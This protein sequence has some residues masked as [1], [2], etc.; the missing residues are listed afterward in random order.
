MSNC[1][2]CYQGCA[3]TISD[4]CIK[5]TGID[6]PQ[7]GIVKGDSLAVVEQKIFNHLRVGTGIVIDLSGISICSIMQDYLPASQDYPPGSEGAPTEFVLNDVLAALIQY[8]CLLQ[9]QIGLQGQRIADNNISAQ[10]LI[11]EER[12]ART[13]EFEA[14]TGVISTISA[15]FTT[16]IQE[17]IALI[18]SESIARATADSATASVIETVSASINAL[19]LDVNAKIVQERTAAVT[20]EQAIATLV[21]TVSAQLNT[22][23]G[24][25]QAAVT[26][27]AQSIATESSARAT[28][29]TNLNAAIATETANRGT[30]ISAASVN[31]LQEANATAAAARATLATNLTAAIN[32]EKTNRE[33]AITTLQQADVTESTARAALGTTLNAAINTEKTNREAAVA[34]LQQADVTESQARATLGTNLTAA[35]NTEASN[36]AAAITTLN[37]AIANETSA[38]ASAITTLSS[39]VNNNTASITQTQQTLAT[40]DGK[41]NA[42]YGLSVDANGRIASMKL[43]SNGVSSEVAF[44][45]DSFKI[46]NGT[47]NVAPFEVVGNQV[48]LKGTTVADTLITPG[49]GPAH[50]AAG[51]NG[52][53]VNRGNDNALRFRHA[54]GV[55]GIE[56]GIIGGQLTLNWFNDQG[57]LVWQGGSSGIVYID[58]VPASWNL[59]ELGVIS[60]TI[61]ENPTETQK[62]TLRDLARFRT[63][64]Y[65]DNDG[66]ISIGNEGDLGYF[67]MN[68]IAKYQYSAGQNADAAG[69]RL[70]EGVYN[71]IG[72]Q[73]GYIDDGWYGQWVTGFPRGFVGVDLYYFKNGKIS[74]NYSFSYNTA[75]Y[76][77]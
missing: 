38:R 77:M 8:S 10:A 50:P 70:Y 62:E 64:F 18:T 43:L 71:G 74:S 58:N 53:S 63:A 76:G 1:D 66:I 26:Q 9:G 45:A 57:M 49:T 22:E 14:V 6:I 21:E 33:A 41:L 67:P 16:D 25:R 17:A 46:F 42:S 32:T 20:R 69:N 48:V 39:T 34:T 29:A 54:N 36:R 72:F 68:R 47:S 75:A 13:N 11:D 60:A 7:L 3:E 52:L 65:T 30:A 24:N 40:V 73:N 59:I 2:N 5:Y 28:L 15:T 51:W 56:I 4:K 27:L 61:G 12:F 23:T 31:T 44:K 19:D 55:V 35:I 37:T